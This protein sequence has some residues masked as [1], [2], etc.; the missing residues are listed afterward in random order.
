MS[1]NTLFHKPVGILFAIGAGILECLAIVIFGI[2]AQ[3]IKPGMI[4][5]ISSNYSLISVLF[6]VPVLGERLMANQKFGIGVVMC[7][8]TMLTVIHI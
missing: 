2:A 1:V 8:L 6:G 4:A 3:T 5:A 7:G